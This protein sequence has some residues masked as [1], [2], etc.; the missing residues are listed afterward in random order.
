M[1][2]C[3]CSSLL[4]LK[5]LFFPVSCRC[6]KHV[7]PQFESAPLLKCLILDGV[8]SVAKKKKPYH[9]HG[10]SLVWDGSSVTGPSGCCL[11]TLSFLQNCHTVRIKHAPSCCVRPR[12]NFGH[13]LTGGGNGTGQYA[14]FVWPARAHTRVPQMTHMPSLNQ[15]VVS[16]SML[17]ASSACRSLVTEKKRTP[18]LGPPPLKSARP[19]SRR[20][21]GPFSGTGNTPCFFFSGEVLL[22]LQNILHEAAGFPYQEKGAKQRPGFYTELALRPP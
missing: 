19:F 11:S 4:L 13:F 3:S 9:D 20:R 6:Q 21:I 10:D 5:Q 18:H 22:L 1:S 17:V 8:A 2:C 7:F 12:L 16:K 15:L 14:T